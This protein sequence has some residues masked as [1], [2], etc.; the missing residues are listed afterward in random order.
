[1]DV[2][3]N[4]QHGWR[5]LR[6]APAFA[7]FSVITL[8]LAIG[9]TTAV[10]SLI[11]AVTGPPPGIAGVDRVVEVYHYPTGSVP[12]MNLAW[13]DYQDLRARQTVFESVTGWTWFRASIVAKGQTETS[14]A[15]IVDGDYFRTLGVRM[16][17][18]RALQP[19]DDL[20]DA[21]AV[22]VIS[23]SLWQR[24]F[25]GA[26]DAV[27]QT[28]KISGTTF[29]IVG[30]ADA[31]FQGLFNGGLIASSLWVPMQTARRDFPELKDHFTP[32]LRDRRWVFVRG[33]LAAG[34]TVTQAMAQVATIGKQLDAAF[35]LGLDRTPRSRWPY[36][37][38]RPWG[39]RTMSSRLMGVPAPLMRLLVGSTMGAVVLVL[40]VACTNLANLTLARNLRRRGEMGTRV[41]LGASRGQLVLESIAEP[42]ILTI[43]G[44]V[45]GMGVAGMLMKV[46]STEVAITNGP[47]LQVLPRL[48][49]ATLAAGS[50]ATL[51]TL[52]VAGVVPVL[53][54]TRVDLRSVLAADGGGTV[55]RWRGRR[56]LIAMQVTV[57]V[58]LVA[59][60]TLYAGE[61]RRL[62]Q[63]DTG[64][65]IE[66]LALAQ[67]DFGSQR[68]DQDRAR[69]VAE[70]AVRQ[71]ALRPGVAA[72]SISSGLPAGLTTTPGATLTPADAPGDTGVAFVAGTP[73]VFDTLGI[74]ILRGRAFEARD[75]RGRAPVVL[76]SDV[77]ARQLF[78]DGEPIGRD[79]IFKRR[80]VVGEADRPAVTMTVIGVAADTDAKG[81]GQRA[82]GVAYLPLDQHYEAR[83]VLAARVDGE[84][85][86]FVG[87]LRAAISSVDSDLA[88]VQIGTGLALAGPDTTFARIASASASLLGLTALVLALA[89]LYGVLSQVVAG[90]TRE[91]GVRLALGAG[92]PAIR[93]MVIAQGLSPIVIGLVAG[94]GF[95]LMARAA[96]QPMFLRL[97]PA[98]DA[99]LM[100]LLPALFLGA[101]LGACYFPAYRASRIDPSVALRNL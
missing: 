6:S 96:M 95:G 85:E 97:V 32:N 34:Q 40:L 68:Y 83:L 37:I 48:D 8:A 30:V 50:C 2:S 3:R 20:P 26:A 49:P 74:G 33:R 87:Q 17:A 80:R 76:L 52:L 25:G 5:R 18:G 7:A 21:P 69:Q 35:P 27:G 72:V 16:Q 92:A 78:P 1:M 94:L 4:L 67:V 36:D 55:A 57:S 31:E 10:Y 44:G 41:A 13:E 93:R 59:L 28:M 79:V 43:S 19:Q 88:L 12:M 71:M 39:V 53:Q 82:S 45:A 63:I 90:R 54:S 24:R 73:G 47:T 89:G 91:I 66:R 14:T 56:Y 81:V 29:E 42:L 38:A 77:A 98:T 62:S 23:D 61:V 70:N 22:A 51:I 65:N 100:I 11:H 58:L 84:P 64:M 15:E 60:A 101:G 75:T 46:L 99:T 9:A 86:A